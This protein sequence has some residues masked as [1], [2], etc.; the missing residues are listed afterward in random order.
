MYEDLLT[1]IFAEIFE[2]KIKLQSFIENFIPVKIDNPNYIQVNTQK[3]FIKIDEHET[4]SRPD[5]VIQFKVNDKKY[6]IF[7]ENK[8]DASE[9]DN[10]LKRYAEHLKAFKNNGF[11]TFLIYITRYDDPKK[12]KVIFINGTTARFVQLRWYKIYNWLKT[13]RDAYIDKILDFMEE[14]GLNQSRRFLPQD[15][16][17]IQEMNRL[18]RMMDECLDGTVD[19]TMTDLFGRAIGWSNRNVQLRDNYRYFKMNDQGNWLTWVGCGFHISEEEYPLVC[20]TFEV[21]P[22]YD[23]RKDV[24]EIM[25]TFVKDKDEWVEY[26]LDDDAKWAGISCDKYLLEFL[27]DEDH[28]LSIQKFFIEKLKELFSIKQKCPNLNWKE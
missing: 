17:A 28:I 9:G 20:V 15:I 13:Q 2:D 19:E 21:S 12:E 1:E 8:V 3:I 25:K 18:Q 11:D 23:K 4:D 27:K 5:L 26:E 7:F 10:Q 22:S 24:V 6:I 16:Y 14:I